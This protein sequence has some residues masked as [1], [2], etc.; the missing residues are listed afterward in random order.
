[1]VEVLCGAL[2]EDAKGE[3]SVIEV[4]PDVNAGLELEESEKVANR[5]G[6]HDRCPFASSGL[7]R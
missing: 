4:E 5:Y 1:M 7:P 6:E 2:E 3:L